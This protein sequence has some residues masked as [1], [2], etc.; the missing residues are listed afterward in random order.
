VRS[1]P[2]APA[3]SIP[4]WRRSAGA[5]QRGF[6]YR[7][8]RA[9]LLPQH[10]RTQNHPCGSYRLVFNSS[11]NSILPLVLC[12]HEQY[13]AAANTAIGWAALTAIQPGDITVALVLLPS[14]ATPVEPTTTASVIWRSQNSANT[15]NHVCVG[16]L[17]GSGITDVNDNIIIGHPHWCAQV[18]LA[19]R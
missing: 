18:A 19:R 7:G 11:G 6:Q 14:Q 12:A 4:A 9:A 10:Q 15:S 3:T 16:R 5:K 17:A 13:A 2:I 1:L 8:R